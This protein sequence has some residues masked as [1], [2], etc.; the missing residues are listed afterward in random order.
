M[1]RAPWRSRE[2]SESKGCSHHLLLKLIKVL[3]SEKLSMTDN[4]LNHF[5]NKDLQVALRFVFQYGGS[6][7]YLFL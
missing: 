1:V 2:E 5:V 3:N 6:F 7:L 4:T